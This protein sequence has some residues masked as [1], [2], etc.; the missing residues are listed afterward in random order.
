MVFYFK[1]EFYAVVKQMNKTHISIFQG[2]TSCPRTPTSHCVIQYVLFPPNILHKHQ[3][4]DNDYG[5]IVDQLKKKN[6][7][8][9]RSSSSSIDDQLYIE[10][11]YKQEENILSS[12]LYI[13][14]RRHGEDDYQLITECW[15]EPQHGTVV[16]NK[17]Q[18]NSYM[19][20]LTYEQLADAVS[21]LYIL[22]NY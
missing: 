15:I 9:E 8:Y 6:N 17:N 19:S 11:R 14:T 22:F 1:P 10:K 5:S 3:S 7:E 12:D 21:N 4:K 20:G 16:V 18:N 13:C 2:S